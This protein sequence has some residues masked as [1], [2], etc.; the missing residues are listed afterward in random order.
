MLGL[1]PLLFLPPF[2]GPITSSTCPTALLGLGSSRC[3]S[4]LFLFLFI[5]S[6]IFFYVHKKLGESQM[7]SWVPFTIVVLFWLFHIFNSSSYFFC[8]LFPPQSI[9]P[10]SASTLFLTT[11][12]HPLS[13]ST[14]LFG[15]VLTPSPSHL[16]NLRIWRL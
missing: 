9:G 1:S 7:R 13:L 15:L 10:Y 8:V 4:S 2:V 3:P 11:P 16:R 12:F 5:S 6:Y 14:I